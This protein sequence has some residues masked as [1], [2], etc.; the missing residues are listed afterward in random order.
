MTDMTTKPRYRVT[1]GKALSQEQAI[2]LRG[3]IFYRHLIRT[4]TDEILKKAG[5][6]RYA[7]KTL[8]TDPDIDQA[9]DR[10]EEELSNAAYTITPS[11]GSVADFVYEQLDLHLETI[12]QGSSLSKWYGYDVIEMLWGKDSG[13]R[14]AVISMMS[15]PIQWFEP[16]PAGELQWFPND[17]S[18]P[19][20]ISDQADFYY[21]YLYQQ[22]KPTYLN[23][24]GK[25]LLSRVYWL[26]YFKTNAWRF[27]SKFLERFGSPLLIGKTDATS[28]D[29]A[30]D[31]A[32]AMLAAHN[33]GVVTI[34]IDEDVKAVTAGS[35][36]EAFVSYDSVVKQSI[37]TYLLGQT[38]T[39]GTDK[40]GTYGQ[41]VV[42]QEQQEIIF[43]SDRKHAIKAVQRFIDV[44]CIANGFEIPE[45]KWVAK[46]FI[47]QE[48]LDADKKAH[49]MGVRFTKSYFVD[50]HGYN[51]QH[52]AQ[53]DYGD[54]AIKLPTSA[55]A[56]RYPSLAKHSWVPF[57]AAE[58]DGEFTDE[59]MELEKVADDA[60]EL[61]VQPFDANTVLS[62][63]ADAT[64]IDSLREALFNMVGD[65]LA[66]SD[67]TQLV[68]TAIQVADV[69]GFA[70]ES[71]EV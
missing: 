6:S 33:S 24:K 65:S 67:F 27:W 56:N 19:I 38:L 22:H 11:E 34:G 17:G 20:M 28:D 1:A 12:L 13:G 29:D 26:H 30:Q 15:K 39:S 16:L 62:A 14:N 4:D 50:E 57:K 7:L 9:I 45:F 37:T 21:R 48:Q 55:Q 36:G 5:I 46:K 70:D 3:K 2:D 60:L 61:S 51:E 59:Q 71:S 44:I 53:M 52:I 41:G 18:E 63:I 68:N 69:H 58:S 10:R 42:H 40:G 64:D 54:G 66:E 47:D 43:S 23:P 8:L 32:N 25:S 35:N 49:E 31:F